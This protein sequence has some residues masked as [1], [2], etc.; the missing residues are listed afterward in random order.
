MEGFGDLQQETSEFKM[1][2]GCTRRS[3]SKE[4][5]KNDE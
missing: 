3:Y 5:V 4:R 2:V 1:T